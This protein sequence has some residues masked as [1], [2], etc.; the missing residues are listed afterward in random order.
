ML[1]K[2]TSAR[3]TTLEEGGKE[4]QARCAGDRADVS[5]PD[6]QV[7]GGQGGQAD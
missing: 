5:L 2:R 7:D 3:P 4:G 6:A 1:R